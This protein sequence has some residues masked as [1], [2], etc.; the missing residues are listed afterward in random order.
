M[1]IADFAKAVQGQLRFVHDNPSACGANFVVG[2]QVFQTHDLDKQECI[3]VVT[4]A[5]EG[6]KF[7]D[8][9]MWIEHSPT[10]DATGLPLDPNKTI[11]L[12]CSLDKVDIP[13]EADEWTLLMGAKA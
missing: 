7:D 13:P 2:M 3:D 10:K 5:V 6:L 12:R 8:W 9:R 4:N 1:T 11:A